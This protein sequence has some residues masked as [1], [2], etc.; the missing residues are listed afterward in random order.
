MEEIAEESSHIEEEEEKTDKENINPNIKKSQVVKWF[1]TF[2]QCPLEKEK[3]LQLITAKMNTRNNGVKE[4]TIGREKHVDGN[5]HIHCLIV[6]KKKV[7]WNKKLFDLDIE[8]IVYH[9]NYQPCKNKEATIAYI[10]K[11]GDYI[12]NEEETKYKEKNQSIINNELV[13][14][15]NIG[16]ISIHS[17]PTLYRAK[18]IYKS[19]AM[20]C[21]AI[22]PRKCIWI[23]G[24]PGVGKSFLARE[25]FPMIYNK[26][27]SIWW[28]GYSGQ[29]EILIED[30]DR[31]LK[32]LSSELKIWS[33]SYYFEGEIKNGFCK[34]TYT[35]L[36][37]TS[38]YSIYSLFDFDAELLQAISRRFKIVEYV[39]RSMHD[40][41][42]NRI[43]E[44][45]N[46]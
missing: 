33:D 5:F 43:N 32:N 42:S 11:Y 46:N 6:L 38:N 29:N 31:S 13:D 26:P 9:G 30:W 22:I 39:D 8:N 41:V 27:R 40:I 36:I 7:R 12:S 4:Y 17:L 24:N 20:K 21:D 28:D 25:K 1:L 15:I 18:Y 16:Q 45:I 3:V 2:P 34:P 44:Y 23:V 14:L 35:I 19:L 10:K 37:V